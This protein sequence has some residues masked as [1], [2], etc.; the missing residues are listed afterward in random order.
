MATDNSNSVFEFRGVKDLFYAQILEDSEENFNTGAPMRLSYVATISKETEN[1]SETHFYDNKGMIVIAAKGA[2]T[3]TLT[4]APLKLETLADITGQGFDPTTG[5]MYE[6]D[7]AKAKYFAIGYKAKGTDGFYRY[8]WKYKGLFGIPS[9][10][11]N[12]ESNSIDTTNTE[13]TYTAV[14]PVHKIGGGGIFTNESTSGIIVDERYGKLT[15]IDTW[16][17]SKVQ[18]AETLAEHVSTG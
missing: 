5:A 17:T 13:L 7:E 1:S 10:E 2:T 3:Y 18:T 9:E 14:T 12:T 16:W 8:V 11:V 4:V 6:M 15:D